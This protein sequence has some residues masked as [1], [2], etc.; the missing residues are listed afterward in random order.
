MA[1]TE[2]SWTHRRV[3]DRII[4]GYTINP[5]IGCE[6]VGPGCANC[7][8]EAFND[9]RLKRG[10]W[11]PH[12]VRQMTGDA[13]WTNPLRWNRLAEKDGIHRFVFCASWADVW[14]KKAPPGA[15][16]RLF[17]LIRA[18]PWLIWLLLSKRIGNAPGMLPPF[19]DEIKD[20]CVIMATMV[21]QPEVDRDMHKLLAV[22][23]G[24]YGIS[25]EPMLGPL[26][27]PRE[28][29]DLGR[30]AWAIV[31]GESIGKEHPLH[32]DWVRGVRDQCAAGGANGPVPFHFKQ[33]GRWWP[34]APVYPDEDTTW[35]RLYVA[36]KHGLNADPDE[37]VV[38][39]A[40]AVDLTLK[41]ERLCAMDRD[42]AFSWHPTCAE[43]VQPPPAAGSWWFEDHGTRD[44]R[45]RELDGRVHDEHPW[46]PCMVK[47]RVS[48]AA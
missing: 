28:F 5:W 16:E 29:L 6:K 35:K 7:Y 47:E 34:A 43:E 10:L 26:I 4:P 44:A 23:A 33:W 42:G 8:A 39:A 18:T 37:W 32:P 13:T 48:E 41:R 38:D 12:A 21:S 24:A 20:R 2:I 9:Q 1:E 45:R 36:Q 27:L 46:V 22:D 30:R 15:R 11:G 31:G 25:M 40:D 14:D 19:W 17:E 3:G